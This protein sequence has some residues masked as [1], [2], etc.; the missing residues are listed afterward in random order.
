MRGMI[1]PHGCHAAATE[2]R[3]ATARRFDQDQP[4][5][6]RDGVFLYDEPLLARIVL[7]GTEARLP[8][9]QERFAM[10]AAD[11]M[12]EK[13]LSVGP[14]TATTAAA[15]VMLDN[16]VSGLPVV[17]GSGRLL[18][19]VTEGDFL[20][21]AETGTERRRSRWLEFLLGPGRLAA[22]Y[23]H[24]HGRKVDEVMTR[25]VVSVTEDVPLEE[26]VRLM[27]R[28]RIKRVPVLRGGKLVGIVSRANLLRAL[29]SVAGELH[30]AAASDAEL[31]RLV[32]AEL[33]K[34][35]WSSGNA[36]NV[37]VRD[38][39][40]QF[41]GVISDD[42]Q[43]DALRVMVENIAGA[44]GMKDNLIWVEPMSGLVI[45]SPEDQAERP[46]PGGG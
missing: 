4:A 9:R 8:R 34:Q 14:D 11:V 17:D 46:A 13:V 38:G 40:V 44:K 37:V 10:N 25:D 43:R 19:I 23:V 5:P 36:I 27:E 35:P 2:G 24:T 29:A 41:W 28:R 22:D 12:T 20:R 21:R 42:R 18:G 16:N 7:A 39:I 33:E 30:P 15:R 26:I 32:L 45:E 1:R 6:C 31:R 3:G